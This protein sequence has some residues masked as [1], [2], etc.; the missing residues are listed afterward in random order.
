[1]AAVTVTPES[2]LN[3]NPSLQS[4]LA[5]GLNMSMGE[6][7]FSTY[8][9]GGVTMSIPH[10]NNVVACF[11]ENVAGFVFTYVPSTGKVLVYDQSGASGALDAVASGATITATCPFVA[12]G[13][14]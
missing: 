7:T 6:A 3:T 10:L 9:S 14:V 1:M 11:I 8:E 12:F 13:F 2:R 5:R 4:A